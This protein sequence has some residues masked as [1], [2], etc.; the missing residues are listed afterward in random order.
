MPLPDPPIPS[1]RIPDGIRISDEEVT[2]QG[3][4]VGVIRSLPLGYEVER[5]DGEKRA[6]MSRFAALWWLTVEKA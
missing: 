6:S 1:Q 5:L 4:R 2:F 3:R